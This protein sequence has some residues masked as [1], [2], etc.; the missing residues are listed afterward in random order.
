MNIQ[1]NCWKPFHHKPR[2]NWYPTTPPV[3]DNCNQG[4]GGGVGRTRGEGL[5]LGVDVGRGVTVAVGLGVCVGVA[6]AVAVAVGVAVAVPGGVAVAVGVGLGVPA[7]PTVQPPVAGPP[8][9][10]QKY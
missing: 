3:T 7:G 6:V 4:L 5:D 1:V 8:E 2:G 10:L 9:P